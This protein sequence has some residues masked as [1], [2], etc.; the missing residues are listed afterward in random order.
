VTLLLLV[1]DP[2]ADGGPDIGL[3]V[4]RLAEMAGR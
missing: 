4:A 3:L 2:A 1:A